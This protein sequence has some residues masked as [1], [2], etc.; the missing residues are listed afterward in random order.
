MNGIKELRNYKWKEDKNGRQLNE[1]SSNGFDHFV[2]AVALRHNME[3][4][5]PEL[6]P[7]PSSDVRGIAGFLLLLYGASTSCHLLRPQ[8]SHLQA[9]QTETDPIRRLDAVTGLGVSKLRDMP[10][11]LILKGDAYLTNLL[12]NEAPDFQRIVELK[13]TRYGFILN[14]EEF[15]AGEWIDPGG[16]LRR[17]LKNGAQCY[18]C[19]PT[20]PSTGNQG[21]AYTIEKYT[22]KEDAD[23][24]LDMPAPYGR[25]V[26]F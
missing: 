12:A 1:P 11:P 19:P 26:A 25:C 22:A 15:T 2:D 13:G 4:N 16:L 7:V 3:P 18:E 14:W 8:A 21:D 6:W 5:K 23:V 17:L 20:D 10:Q 24:F 9:L